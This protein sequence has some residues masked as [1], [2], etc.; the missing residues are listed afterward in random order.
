MRSSPSP[1]TTFAQAGPRSDA[2]RSI[3]SRLVRTIIDWVLSAY[4][5]DPDLPDPALLVLGPFMGAQFKADFLRRV[6]CLDKV[7][8]ITFD[9]HIESLMV[10]AKGIVCMGG[11]NTFCEVLSFDKRALVVPRTVP[12][13]EQVIR[14]SRA[15]ELGLVRMLV[16]D[17]VRDPRVMAQALR[18]LP[19]QT[20]PS[21]VV[22][23]GLLDGRKNVIAQAH[24][25]LHERH[26][27]LPARANVTVAAG[28]GST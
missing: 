18:R 22:V 24:E 1:E 16:D 14:A 10:R 11:Y 8:A 21:S 4:E 13:R 17:G 6:A 12:R 9:A 28:R 27:A 7:E 5:S 23:P 2:I 3:R 20:L 25:W 26:R 19:T 15:Q